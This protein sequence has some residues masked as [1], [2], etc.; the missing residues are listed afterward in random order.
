METNLFTK[1]IILKGKNGINWRV[2]GVYDSEIL[3][4]YKKEQV[5]FDIKGIINFIKMGHITVK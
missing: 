2:I 1:N 4:Q 3:L 5:F